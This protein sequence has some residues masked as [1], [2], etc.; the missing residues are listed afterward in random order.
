MR[1]SETR[2]RAIRTAEVRAGGA[3]AEG[4][5]GAE[6]TAGGAAGR[7]G[8]VIPTGRKCRNF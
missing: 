8:R 2:I 7:E 1:A 3:A 5:R 6:D 4:G